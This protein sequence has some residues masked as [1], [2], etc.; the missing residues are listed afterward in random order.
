MRMAQVLR[1]NTSEAYLRSE[2]P[3]E[4]PARRVQ[5]PRHL[6]MVHEM[7]RRYRPRPTTTSTV[8]TGPV[9][10]A[11]IA[12]GCGRRVAAP[13]AAPPHP[14]VLVARRTRSHAA[15]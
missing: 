1:T 2:S 9:P 6:P 15:R 12:Q 10:L 8:D 11:H 4:A 13:S 7:A 3:D 5:A 14:T